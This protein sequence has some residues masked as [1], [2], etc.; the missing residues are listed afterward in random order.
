VSLELNSILPI[1]GHLKPP[2]VKATAHY[3]AGAIFTGMIQFYN[4]DEPYY[5]FTNFYK[6]VVHIDDKDWPTTEH[7]YQA[8][9][10]TES[11]V[12]EHIRR[13]RTPREAFNFG[14]GHRIDRSD[15]NEIKEDI[16]RIALFHKFDQHQDLREKLLSTGNKRLVEHTSRDS[17]WGDGGDGKGKNRLG[18]LLME[19]RQN[20]RK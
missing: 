15:W 11:A 5:E 6:R 17:Y 3:T 2:T 12:K 8:Q 20:L 4:K 14:R 13:M 18:N 1:G 9:K 19:V 10:F 16:M 7:Y